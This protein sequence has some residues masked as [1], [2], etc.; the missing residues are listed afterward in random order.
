MA[1]GIKKK[2]YNFPH[3]LLRI[4]ERLAAFMGELSNTPI[5]T[6][7]HDNLLSMLKLNERKYD[8]RY[9]LIAHSDTN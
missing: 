1:E 9:A 4:E 2:I 3:A 5:A 7:A 8:N 6:P